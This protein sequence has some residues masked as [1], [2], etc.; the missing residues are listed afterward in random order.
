MELSV[1]EIDVLYIEFYITH[2]IYVS[3]DLLFAYFF[4]L[5]SAV[6]ALLDAILLLI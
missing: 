1:M 5:L 3:P 4:V 6:P 2:N